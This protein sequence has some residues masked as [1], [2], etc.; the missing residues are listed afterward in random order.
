MC[1]RYL[2]I[3]KKSLML[4]WIVKHK[5]LFDLLT[6]SNRKE[7][8]NFGQKNASTPIQLNN[9]RSIKITFIIM[10]YG[11]CYKVDLFSS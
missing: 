2:I 7:S 8:M 6:V 3:L 9:I 5:K 11:M 10:L 1:P 4:A